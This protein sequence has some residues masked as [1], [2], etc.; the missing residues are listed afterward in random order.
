MAV[1]TNET[2]NYW[3]VPVNLTGI[4]GQKSTSQSAHVVGPDNTFD[5]DPPGYPIYGV[6]LLYYGQIRISGVT[7]HNNLNIQGIVEFHVVLMYVDEL[8]TQYYGELTSAIGTESPYDVGPDKATGVGFTYSPDAVTDG[9]QFKVGDWIIF[10]DETPVPDYSQPPYHNPA[11]G[12]RYECAQIVGPGNEGDPITGGTVDIQRRYP[13]ENPGMA[14][15][16]SWMNAHAAG[17][18]FFKLNAGHHVFKVQPGAFDLGQKILQTVPTTGTVS[19]VNN[20]D[21]SSTPIPTS[22]P[23][24]GSGTAWDSSLVG[25]DIYIA[26][27]LS[28]NPFGLFSVIQ[29]VEDATH[30]T[31][32]GPW[33]GDTGSGLAYEVFTEMPGSGTGSALPPNYDCV[34]PNA[35][36][37][38]ALAGAANRLGYSVFPYYNLS[39]PT[40]MGIR[41]CSGNE[42]RF[43]VAGT[44]ATAVDADTRYRMNFDAV[45]RVIYGEVLGAPTDPAPGNNSPILVDI[46]VSYDEGVTWTVLEGS[47]SPDTFEIRNTETTSYQHE[48]DPPQNVNAPYGMSFP[49]PRL[50]AGALVGIDIKQVGADSP[51]DTLVA[52]I[53][54]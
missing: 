8:R 34:Q 23:V 32:A 46:K 5:T 41:T 11:G 21:G 7:I 43:R 35:M 44:L 22:T 47:A 51:G 2:W 42:I 45:P 54:V 13:G 48:T 37:V 10:N 16:G 1:H 18:R 52:T 27:T 38:C 20:W 36:V 3:L 14:T 24:V 50:P 33:Q 15:F 9:V 6:E 49:Y 17:K 31:V 53:V 4:P 29:S 12:R 19:L 25:D 30:M 28:G 40:R 26:G 39:T